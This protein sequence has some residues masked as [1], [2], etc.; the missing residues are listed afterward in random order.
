MAH[1]RG[2]LPPGSDEGHVHQSDAGGEGHSEDEEQVEDE[3]P[4]CSW[5]AYTTRVDGRQRGGS[6]AK[7]KETV[8]NVEKLDVT[9]F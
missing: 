5:E 6:K 4:R 9:A 1:W 7:E 3:E 8:M 2:M